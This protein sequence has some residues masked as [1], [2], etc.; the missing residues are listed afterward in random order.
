MKKTYYKKIDYI[1]VLLCLSVL[2]YHVGILKGGYLAVNCFFALSGYL[3]I[4]S[5]LEKKK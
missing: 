4:C 2:F 3:A 1:R 5:F